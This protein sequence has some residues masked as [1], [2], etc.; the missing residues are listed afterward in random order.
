MNAVQLLIVFTV[1]GGL[2][3][4]QT[5]SA[6]AFQDQ[7]A[8]GQ[9][10]EPVESSKPQAP[11][12]VD[13]APVAGDEQIADR[14]DQ[15]LESTQWFENAEVFVENGVV[16]LDGAVEEEEYKQWA[17]DL[18]GNTQDVV[19]VVNRI[20]VIEKSIWDFS[21]AVNELWAF[22]A[23]VVQAI[24]YFLFGLIVLGITWLVAKIT[25]SVAD[26]VLARRVPNNLLRWVT[27]LAIVLPI[28]IFG[29][30]LVLR[31]SGLTQLALTVLG[32]TGLV[33]LVIGI[34]FQDIAE[35]FLASILIST[36]Q[37]FRINDLIEINGTTG[38]VRRVTTRGTTLLTQDGNLVQI[39]NSQIYKSVIVNFT[40]SPSRRLAFTVGIGYDDSVSQA[41]KIVLEKIKQHEATLADPPPRVLIENLGAATVNM[42]A[43]FW[44]DGSR[45]DVLSAKS[46]VMRIAKQALQQAGVSMPDESR[47]VIFPHGVPVTI[48][49]DQSQDPSETGEDS[50]TTG[51]ASESRTPDSAKRD[52]V[53][54]HPDEQPV[55]EA[56]GNL[57]TET[58]ELQRQA[59]TSWLPGEGS[60]IL[61][62]EE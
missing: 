56:E 26:R 17:T 61:V 12:K 57:K 28:Y 34:A 16:F 37:P 21:G 38:I 48:E 53:A 51:E 15:I 23:G 58:D 6:L 46:S 59:E 52:R 33:G 4:L 18:A 45:H 2:I 54:D 32:G 44:I 10:A 47:E 41:Q 42:Q 50:G 11:E 36:Q 40:A 39:P 30:Y 24:P 3:P 31:V 14:L 55:S 62:G 25:G 29:I 35:N 8:S 19:A 5:S 13:V 9:Q 60:D 27:T 7:P 22:R 43:L 1:A 20:T 49:R